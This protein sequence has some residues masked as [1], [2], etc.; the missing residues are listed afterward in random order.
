[1][2]TS[3]STGFDGEAQVVRKNKGPVGSTL[4]IEMQSR[5][6]L[7]RAEPKTADSVVFLTELGN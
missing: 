4:R 3:Y 6:S 2:F 5:V 1:M 7:G